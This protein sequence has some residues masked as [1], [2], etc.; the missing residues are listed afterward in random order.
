MDDSPENIVRRLL[1]VVGRE[2]PYSA[3]AE[4]LDEN[5][6]AF[7]DGKKISRGRDAWFRWVRFL[8]RRAKEQYSDFGMQVESVRDDGGEVAVRAKWRG[9]RGGNKTEFSETGE[10]FYEVRGGKIINI[11]TKR[12]N[13]VFIHGQ[14]IAKFRPA[15][16]FL[17]LRMAL[18]RAPKKNG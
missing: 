9:V 4:L 14:S 10:V 13:Y 5:L 12:K 15:F 2:L 7:M 16:W 11:W 3:A 1:R 18:S 6:S 17:L 8:H